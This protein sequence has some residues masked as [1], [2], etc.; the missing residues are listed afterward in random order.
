[1]DRWDYRRTIA[2]LAGSDEL[3]SAHLAEALH[4]TQ[5]SKDHD[6]NIALDDDQKYGL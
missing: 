4:A 3:Q 5:P 1:M 2:E 6:V